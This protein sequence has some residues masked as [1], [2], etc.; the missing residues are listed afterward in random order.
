V[1]L[2]AGGAD[3]HDGTRDRWLS[4]LAGLV[5][6][7]DVNG[8]LAGRMVRILRD[9]GRLVDAP[10]R[11]ER[12]LSVGVPAAHKAAWVDGFFAD[13]ALLL[14][15]DRELLGLLDTW[16]RGLAEPDFVDVLPLVRRTFGA[17]SAPERRSIAT[18][19]RSGAPGP[20]TPSVE[21]V[22]EERALAAVATVATILGVR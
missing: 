22:D 17:F 18:R 6:R 12:A 15:H 20:P 9:A 1:A 21:D 3:S 19:V 16:V 8:V 4:T 7:S 14:M 5:D 13:G 11:L 2:A 10:T